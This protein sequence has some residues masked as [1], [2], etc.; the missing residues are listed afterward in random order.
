[1]IYI[2]HDSKRKK[3][4]GVIGSAAVLLFIIMLLGALMGLARG[5]PL[6]IILIPVLAV[7]MFALAMLAIAAV[8]AN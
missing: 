7:V 4:S 8:H 5:K 3:V 6:A 1:M 2:I